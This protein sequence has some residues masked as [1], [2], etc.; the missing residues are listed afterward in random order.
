MAENNEWPIHP[1]WLSIKEEV[2]ESTTNPNYEGIFKTDTLR[3]FI[4]NASDDDAI[5]KPLSLFQVIPKDYNYEGINKRIE[6]IN[7]SF[8]PND[9]IKSILG[10]R[11]I[12]RI[13]QGKLFKN[14]PCCAAF[15]DFK[16]KYGNSYKRK[17]HY[18]SSR[19]AF[20]YHSDLES[21]HFNNNYGVYLNILT[22]IIKEYNDSI[23]E[24][25]NGINEYPVYPP[26]ACEFLIHNKIYKS[27]YI[28]YQCP[29]SKLYE[30]IFPIIHSGKVIAVII[31]G[32]LP[33]E[34]LK[35]EDMF[36]GFQ[37]D[38]PEGKNL[39]KA[40]SKEN[41]P[42][43]FFD[44][45]ESLSDKHRDAI[46]NRIQDLEIRI[47][48]TVISLSQKYVLGKFNEIEKKYR[49]KLQVENEKNSFAANLTPALDKALSE[50]FSTF[51]K[52]GFIRLY[53]RK[54]D[55]EVI[56]NEFL[57]EFTLIG[58][59]VLDSSPNQSKEYPTLQ[60][61]SNLPKK[62]I[63]KTLILRENLLSN[64]IPIEDRDVFRLSTHF[65]A[66]M[67]YV[68]WKRYTSWNKSYPE[69][70]DQYSQSLLGIYPSLLEPYFIARS[71]ELEENL[72]RTMRFTVHESAQVIPSVIESINTDFTRGIMEGRYSH[73]NTVNEKISSFKI[74]DS[75]QRL[76]MLERMFRTSTALFKKSSAELKWQDLYRIIYATDSLFSKK[77]DVEQQQLLK[78]DFEQKLRFC[79]IYTDY[80]SM[81]HIL[82]NFVDNAIKYGFR[83]TNIV[84]SA[85]SV[86][87]KIASSY[88][89]SKRIDEINKIYMT[90]KIDDRDRINKIA[91]VNRMARIE[92]IKEL[93]I[94]VVNYGNEIKETDKIFEL[95]FRS[96]D[97]KNRVEG[98]GIGL[99]LVKKL[100][101][102]LGYAIECKPSTLAAKI[103]LPYYYHYKKTTPNYIDKNLDKQ[104]MNQLNS[105][106]D[107]S[108]IE[109]VVNQ[110]TDKWRIP[111]FE[112]EKNLDT[113]IYK[114]EF[115][116]TIPVNKETFKESM[117]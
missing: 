76:T 4:L 21:I 75:T 93:Q 30:C 61:K 5:N 15:R 92:K 13:S 33:H 55:I 96:E 72:I 82:F 62:D 1:K 59:A 70:Y 64:Q 84:L 67:G 12:I 102:V 23:K 85:R 71:L 2:S 86:E 81:S 54:L 47:N 113:P 77:A 114:N 117:I 37:D 24:E 80:G 20:F 41:F 106:I 45:K 3:G 42:A 110:D 16:D 115:I 7:N 51:N 28:K 36:I 26:T 101:E 25:N 116:I 27:L 94:S 48:D 87:D 9:Y 39:Q 99:F 14:L 43:D 40:M 83:G 58:E 57:E 8:I 6:I 78:I 104:I 60:F 29:Y 52:S 95:Y 105:T 50:I 79:N 69:Q 111:A 97:A 19:M 65:G 73:K 91:E 46:F 68:V 18:L 112:L 107:N 108:I 49:E 100:C 22:R 56:D 63:D 89:E 17:C 35:K 11:D 34:N 103:N 66:K 88:I 74:I 98:M 90:Y 32:Q 31:Q 109:E 10:D 53:T 44:K 38:S